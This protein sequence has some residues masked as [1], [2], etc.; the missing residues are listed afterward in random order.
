MYFKNTLYFPLLLFSKVLHVA[1]SYEEINR[2]YRA[3]SHLQSVSPWRF[4]VLHTLLVSV[5]VQYKAAGIWLADECSEMAIV[6]TI[7]STFLNGLML[8]L[9]QNKL[10]SFKMSNATIIFG[11]PA[12]A[13]YM[14]IDSMH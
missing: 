1:P 5:Y 3:N 7:L 6:C 10:Q 12:P 4:S 8:Y 9:K 14:L 2:D 11:I 13:K